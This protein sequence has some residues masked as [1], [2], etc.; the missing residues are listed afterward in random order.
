METRLRWKRV[1]AIW[2]GMYPVNVATSWA[3][4]MLPWW[5]G[6]ALPA[7]SAIVVTVVAPLMSLI[8]MPAITR[9]LAPWLRRHPEHARRERRLRAVLDELAVAEAETVPLPVI[10]IA[11]VAADRDRAAA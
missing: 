3:I 7:R 8:M 2:I 5:G 10:G 11:R 1:C 6:I 4:T 9:L